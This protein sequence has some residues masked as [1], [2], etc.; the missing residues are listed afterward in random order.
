MFDI[1]S[2]NIFFFLLK[3]LS[4]SKTAN[5]PLYGVKRKKLI[6]INFELDQSI[7]HRVNEERTTNSYDETNRRETIDN[8]RDK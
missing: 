4:L 6:R 3:S 5:E 1:V 7:N 2:L 8:R